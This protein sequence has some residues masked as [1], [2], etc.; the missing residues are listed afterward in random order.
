VEDL[1]VRVLSELTSLKVQRSELSRDGGRVLR[2]VEN[3][4]RPATPLRAPAGPAVPKVVLCA[5]LGETG[6]LGWAPVLPLLAP[7]IRWVAYDR[8]GL[9]ASDPDPSPSLDSHVGDLVALI[10]H[11]GGPCILGGASWGGLI[12]EVAALRHNEL[13]AGLV[14]ADPSDEKMILSQPAAT[15]RLVSDYFDALDEQAAAGTLEHYI[16]DELSG[17]VAKVTSDPGLRSRVMD[18]YVASYGIPS[19]PGAIRSEQRAVNGCVPL[20]AQARAEHSLPDIPLVVFSASTGLPPERRELFTRCHAELAASVPGAKHV[21]V[22]DAGHA[23]QQ[24]CPT[25]VAGAINQM[26]ADVRRR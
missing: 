10:E 16:R 2:W 11:T 19:W 3:V 9:G 13:V 14:L 5:S 23:I 26:L 8:A 6:S 17:D 1:V 25:V 18:A 20:I 12:A 24:D 15:R 4:P 7:E 21:V 22:A